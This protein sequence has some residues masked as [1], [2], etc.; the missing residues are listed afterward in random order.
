[1]SRQ[2]R[3][4]DAAALT[5]LARPSS[6]LVNACIPQ[7]H[8]HDPWRLTDIRQMRVETEQRCVY[9]IGL[10]ERDNR[11]GAQTRDASPQAF[12]LPR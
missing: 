4:A 5:R 12:H 10:I 3:E 6:S 7:D 9:K 8:T 11:L 1:M 2:A